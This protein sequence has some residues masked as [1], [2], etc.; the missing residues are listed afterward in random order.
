MPSIAISKPTQK[1]SSSQATVSLNLLISGISSSKGSFS[2]LG[3]YKRGTTENSSAVR[4]PP[5]LRNGFLVKKFREFRVVIR[6]LAECVPLQ[7]LATNPQNDY[8]SKRCF[9]LKNVIGCHFTMV[10]CAIFQGK[11]TP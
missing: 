9:Y 5:N 11:Y 10:F 2:W 7:Q 8:L 6:K 4:V 3:G 1:D